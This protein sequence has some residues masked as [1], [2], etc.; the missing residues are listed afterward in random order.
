LETIPALARG[1]NIRNGEII[2]P[3]L[4]ANEVK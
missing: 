1:V 3:A 4:H 2:N